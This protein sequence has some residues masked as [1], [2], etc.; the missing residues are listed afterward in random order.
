MQTIVTHHVIMF[1]KI[2]PFNLFVYSGIRT[3]LT[4]NISFTVIIS[5]FNDYNLINSK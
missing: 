3:L 1:Q 4:M 5:D 2:F